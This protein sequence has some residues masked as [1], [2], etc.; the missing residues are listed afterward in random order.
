MLG[1]SSINDSSQHPAQAEGLL[2]TQEPQGV[3]HL[4]LLQDQV[5][6]CFHQ[7]A[8]PGSQ[9]PH[10]PC[11]YFRIPQDFGLWDHVS[12]RLAATPSPVYALS[13]LNGFDFPERSRPCF[14]TFDPLWVSLRGQPGPFPGQW[15]LLEGRCL[16]ERDL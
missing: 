8:S 11:F 3:F 12:S 5:Q 16:A 1:R 6:D 7:E 10:R 15:R 2:K 4:C 13:P 14:I 9:Q